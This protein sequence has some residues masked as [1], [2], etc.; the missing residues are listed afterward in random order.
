MLFTTIFLVLVVAGCAGLVWPSVHALRRAGHARAE[1]HRDHPAWASAAIR[2]AAP[3]SREGVLVA[4]LATG[5]I[6]RRQY[7]RAME[8][9]AARD[10]ARDPLAVPESGSD[11]G[12]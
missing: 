11:T 7:V 10:D 6:T 5:E 3:E 4:Q 8:K 2:D 1:P 9:V 12:L